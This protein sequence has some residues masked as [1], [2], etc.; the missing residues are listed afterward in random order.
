MSM[1]IPKLIAASA[2]ALAFALPAHAVPYTIGNVFV[3]DGAGNVNEYTPTGALVQTLTG[4]TSY[5]TGSAFDSAGNFY[6]TN[7]GGNAV[8]KYDNSGVLQGPFGGGYSTPEMIVVDA[9]GDFY[10][11]NLGGNILKFN[12]AGTLLATI[13]TPRVDFMDLAADQ[14]TMLYGQEGG[15]ILAVDVATNTALPNF[16]TDVEN[17]FAMRLL[18]NGNLLV[19]DGADIELLDTGGNQIGTYDIAGA[20]QWFALNIDVSGTSFWSATTD[21]LVA[22]FDIA[23]GTVLNQWNDTAGVN[24]T[25]GLAIYGEVTQGGGGGETEVPEP[26]TLALLGIGLLGMGLTRRRRRG[27]QAAL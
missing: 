17:A 13:N 7:F 23:T 3:S 26:S 4:G 16:S 9:A 27:N 14:S 6:V 1:R 19:A 10:V 5:M 25:W 8:L 18:A 12:A 11:G 2:L 20:G 22:E 24:G 21:G 15:E